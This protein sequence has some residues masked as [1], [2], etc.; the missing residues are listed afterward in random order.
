MN[1]YSHLVGK[2]VRVGM[3][4][5]RAQVKGRLLSWRVIPDGKHGEISAVIRRRSGATVF[6]GGRFDLE[7]AS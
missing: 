7:R 2:T 4:Q 6:V 3:K 1:D 5:G